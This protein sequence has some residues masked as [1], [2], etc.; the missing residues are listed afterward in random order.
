MR[1]NSIKV[2]FGCGLGNSTDLVGAALVRLLLEES[3]EFIRA[4]KR[5]VMALK[6]KM[7]AMANRTVGTI[8]ATASGLASSE[9]DQGLRA[10]GR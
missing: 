1:G 2:T 8:A 3:K 4:S 7:R 5:L 10:R 9:K 6:T